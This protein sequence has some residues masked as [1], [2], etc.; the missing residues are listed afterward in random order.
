MHCLFWEKSPAKPVDE[1]VLQARAVTTNKDGVYRLIVSYQQLIAWLHAIFGAE[2]SPFL[3]KLL[4]ESV[5][6]Y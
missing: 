1:I 3:W 5:A 2:R 4:T 6:V